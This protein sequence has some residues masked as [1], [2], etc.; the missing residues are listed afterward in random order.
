MYGEFISKGSTLF[1]DQKSW[2]PGARKSPK[3]WDNFTRYTE[4]G[5]L[6]LSNN[7]AERAL[8]NAALG[9]KKIPVRRQRTR[10]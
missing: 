5:D 1:R 3:R 10:R 8:R 9:R 6:N 7:A 2:P 4:R